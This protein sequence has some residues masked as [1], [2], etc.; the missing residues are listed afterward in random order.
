[1]WMMFL[2]SPTYEGNYDVVIYLTAEGTSK[3]YEVTSASIGKSLSFGDNDSS[4]PTPIILEPL[5]GPKVSAFQGKDE[6]EARNFVTILR[7]K[8]KNEANSK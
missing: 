5:R 1:M 6:K 4:L 7:L 2:M 3:L 8:K